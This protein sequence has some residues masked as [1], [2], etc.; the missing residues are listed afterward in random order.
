[1]LAFSPHKSRSLHRT[2]YKI[3]ITGGIA[4]G[5]STVAKIIQEQGEWVFDADA[6]AKDALTPHAQPFKEVVNHFGSRILEPHGTINRKLLAD[7]VFSDPR[8][9]QELEEIVHPFVFSQMHEMEEKAKLQGRKLLFYEIPLLIEIGMQSYMDAVI[10]VWASLEQRV[11]RLIANLGYTR[12][13]ALA[14]INSQMPLE[15]KKIFAD[16]IIDNSQSLAH[17][18]KQTLDVL[19]K[20]REKFK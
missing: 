8:A 20:I 1:M 5:K 7:I 9:R 2:M 12:A 15:Q 19:K 18:R 10:V 13:Q 3:G 11:Q 14:R 4:S 6:A 17:T 16:F